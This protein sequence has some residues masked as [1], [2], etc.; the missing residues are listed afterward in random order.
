[1][2][3]M[4][5]CCGGIWAVSYSWLRHGM[6]GKFVKVVD[7]R[8][9]NGDAYR[10]YSHRDN[11]R[12]IPSYQRAATTAQLEVADIVTVRRTYQLCLLD[13]SD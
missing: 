7:T 13:T 11:A 9:T 1:M 2:K 8:V 3:I 5:Y 6:T 4:M 10:E 12:L